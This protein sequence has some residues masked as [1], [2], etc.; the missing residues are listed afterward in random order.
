VITAVRNVIV[1]DAQPLTSSGVLDADVYLARLGVDGIMGTTAI[2]PP[3]EG[4]P[5]ITGRPVIARGVE[6]TPGIE[7]VVY[8]VGALAPG[9]VNASLL[10]A[11][12]TLL[13]GA[14]DHVVEVMSPTQL[15]A[16]T[17]VENSP[18]SAWLPPLCREYQSSF[19]AAVRAEFGVDIS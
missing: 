4:E 8:V 19:Q 18:V 14:D 11:R 15:C 7:W 12:L 2:S 13:D 6:L 3:G 1:A 5:G 10:G 9:E 17:P 16:G